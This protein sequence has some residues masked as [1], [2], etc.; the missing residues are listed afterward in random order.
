MALIKC[1]ECGSD[2]S[3]QTPA[4]PKCGYPIKNRLL[5]SPSQPNKPIRKGS[6]SKWLLLFLLLIV[7]IL[8]LKN[9]YSRIG[10][11]FIPFQHTLTLVQGSIVAKAGYYRSYEFSTVSNAHNNKLSGRFQ[12]S[13]GSGD[14]IRVIIMTKDDYTNFVNGHSAHC[15]YD[16]GKN[17][18]STIDVDLPSGPQN[19]VLVFD[20]TFSIL[21]DKE[22]NANINFISTY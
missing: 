6:L 18:V 21:T 14:D 2:I 8:I 13:G 10:S 5:S 20:N 17:T 7:L 19:Y 3:D 15:Y 9:N 1:P 16:S 22:V 12:A 11:S 4:C